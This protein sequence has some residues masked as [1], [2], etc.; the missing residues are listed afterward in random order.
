MGDSSGTVSLLEVSSSLAQGSAAEK[1][2]IDSMLKRESNRE[3]NLFVRSQDLARKAR[4]AEQQASDAV[5]KEA[6]GKEDEMEET[7]RRVDAE[8]LA[9]IKEAEEDDEKEGM[10]ED[11]EEE[12]KP[13]GG[14]AS[15]AGR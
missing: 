5:S 15:G 4:R 12:G 7:L 9:M 2:Q 8:F 14:A 1:Q 10:E 11:D 6:G 13:Q 3:R